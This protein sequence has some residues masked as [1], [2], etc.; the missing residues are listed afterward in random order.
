VEE[1]RVVIEFYQLAAGVYLAAAVAAALGFTLPSKRLSRAAVAGLALGVV[2]HAVAF[3]QLHEGERT[4]PL[5]DLAYVVPFVVWMLT[6]FY[7]LLLIRVRLIGL[8]IIV[9]P[10]AFVGTFVE[11]LGAP[12]VAPGDQAESPIWSH[13]HVLLASAGLALLA[14]AGVAG[15]LYVARHRNL[16]SKRPSAVRLPLPSL[17][18]LDR[19][20]VL[21]LVVGFLLLSLGVVTGVLWTH[22]VD[23]RLWPG[24]PHANATLVAWLLLAALVAA[25]F[26]TGQG[27]RQ[28]A[29]GSMAGFAL[30]LIAVIGVGMLA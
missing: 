2:V 15:A 6:L 21:S 11:F 1:V 10:L 24:T 27:A 16:K 4:P 7:L 20:N 19:V 23:G 25:R 13:V 28:S 30:M 9:A 17:E 14:V 29:L 3:W 8:A 26:G 18:A 5:T 12:A 22:A